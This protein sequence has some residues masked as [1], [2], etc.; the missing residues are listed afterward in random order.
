MHGVRSCRDAFVF[1]QRV[2]EYLVA[3][4]YFDYSCSLGY[5]R[6]IMSKSRHHVDNMNFAKGLKLHDLI[7]YFLLLLI[8]YIGL[9]TFFGLIM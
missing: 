2:E 9:K 6:P 3:L 5:E 7:L 8:M 1:M 4:K